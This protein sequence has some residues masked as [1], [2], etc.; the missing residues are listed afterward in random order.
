[1]REGGSIFLEGVPAILDGELCLE[2][3]GTSFLETLRFRGSD[4]LV[5]PL[6]LSF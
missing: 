1:L 6:S 5:T 3:D 4:V 2:N